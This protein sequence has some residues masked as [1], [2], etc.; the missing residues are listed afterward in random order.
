MSWCC[1]VLIEAALMGVAGFQG[2]WCPVLLGHDRS[3]TGCNAHSCC[4]RESSGSLT[5]HYV[6]QTAEGMT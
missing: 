2:L 4:A 6:A 5:L 3:L 1:E